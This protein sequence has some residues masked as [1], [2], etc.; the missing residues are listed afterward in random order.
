M[1]NIENGAPDDR[2]D[3]DL[4]EEQQIVDA[5]DQEDV[6]RLIHENTEHE[7]DR[8]IAGIE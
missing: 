3:D 6:D 2:H 4:V 5:P 1:S 8:F 7:I